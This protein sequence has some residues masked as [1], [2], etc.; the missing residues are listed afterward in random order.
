MFWACCEARA[1]LYAIGELDLHDA[2][3]VLQ[4]RAMRHGLVA[5]IGQATVQAIIAEAFHCAC[6][7]K[8]ATMIA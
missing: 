6:A 7:R 3:D 5:E 1:H 2:V 4:E 8:L